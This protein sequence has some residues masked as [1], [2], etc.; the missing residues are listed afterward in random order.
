MAN[1]VAEL[2]RFLNAALV[3]PVP[4][5][6]TESDAAFRR[7]RVVAATTLVVGLVVNTW[8]LRIEPGN[9]LFYPATLALAA[10]WAFGASGLWKGLELD[11]LHGGSS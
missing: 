1:P 5:D 11:M 4:R 2:R 8:A 6:H 10:V 7:R 9:D 3:T